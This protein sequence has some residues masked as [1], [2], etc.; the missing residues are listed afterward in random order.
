MN[1]QNAECLS[2]LPEES[3]T[4][5]TGA[6]LNDEPTLVRSM[7]GN[8]FAALHASVGFATVQ[9]LYDLCP[10]TDFVDTC[11]PSKGDMLS[12]CTDSPITTKKGSKVHAQEFTCAHTN[13]PASGCRNHQQRGGTTM[14]LCLIPCWQHHATTRRIFARD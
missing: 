10:I 11:A 12:I 1:H 7:L 6:R 14:S 13:S 4:D 9:Q 3:S 5:T 8:Q 2:H